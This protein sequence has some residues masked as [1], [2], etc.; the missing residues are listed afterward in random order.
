MLEICTRWPEPCRRSTGATAWV[1]QTA[2]KKLVSSWA[3]TCSAVNSS[4]NPYERVPALLTTTSSRPKASTARSTAAL[5]DAGSRTSAAIWRSPSRVSSSRT[6]RETAA[7]RSPAASAASV[8]ARPR[9]RLA[10]VTNQVRGGAGV[11]P[12]VL[13]GAVVMGSPSSVVETERLDKDRAGRRIALSIRNV[14][15]LQR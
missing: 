10:P 6:V 1:T 5:T 14:S 15:S 12:V 3:R 2:P 9:P 11:G 4:T 8:K 13:V 7:T